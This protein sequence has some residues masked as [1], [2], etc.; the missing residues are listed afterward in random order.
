MRRF[1]LSGSILL[2]L[3]RGVAGLQAATVY[4]NG[5][6]NQL[7][8]YGL[9]HWIEA[10]NFTLSPGG[11]LIQSIQFWDLEQP[12]YFQSSV[13]WEIHADSNG[14]P[15]ATLF[16]GTS[17]NL[18]HTA[19]GKTDS[20]SGTYFEYVGTFNITSSGLG[21]GNYWLVLH[22]GPLSYTVTIPPYSL[23]PVFW[24][25]TT[26]TSTIQT[27][28]IIAPFTDPWQSNLANSQMAF[29]LT[30]I[31]GPSV[32]AF[33]YHSASPQL[34]FTTVSGQRYSVQYKN[35]MTDST[36]LTLSGGE[37]VAGTGGVIQ[38]TDFSL[39]GLTRRFY[40]AVMLQ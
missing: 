18:T 23:D 2:L 13:Y 15:G 40:R 25:T 14:S 34:S 33:A 19:T 31:F 28:E 35:Q 27:Q 24:E 36:W 22:N 26:G 4:D 30:G 6:P 21:P 29:K 3:L 17:S 20:T 38:V 11:A 32:T 7:Y 39:G 1:F 16:S 9:S 8:G 12:G 5:A 37:N 10:N